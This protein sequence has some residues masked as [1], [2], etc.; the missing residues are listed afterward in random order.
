MSFAYAEAIERGDTIEVAARQALTFWFSERP[1]AEG[2]DRNYR[3]CFEFPDA[4]DEK[5][6]DAAVD[7]VCPILRA[8]SS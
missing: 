6:H 3:R 5:F 1:G 7:I 4:L 2:K 8:V